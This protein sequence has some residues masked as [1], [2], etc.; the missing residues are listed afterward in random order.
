LLQPND[1][2]LDPPNIS[3]PKKTDKTHDGC[4]PGIKIDRRSGAPI[5]AHKFSHFVTFPTGQL[6]DHCRDGVIE[7]PTTGQA[8]HV[9]FF[10]PFFDDFVRD[11][12]VVIQSR[13]NVHNDFAHAV[14]GRLL[15]GTSMQVG[16]VLSKKFTA[17]VGWVHFANY[18]PNAANGRE[19]QLV[20]QL[21][22]NVAVGAAP[23]A[24]PNEA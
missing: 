18:V 21:N 15:Y 24:D 10:L 5:I 6:R 22:W 12:R 11:V 23:P 2:R 7:R 4:L 8:N 14:H 16:H 20:E 17:W 3:G 13:Q 1:Y 19:N 9:A